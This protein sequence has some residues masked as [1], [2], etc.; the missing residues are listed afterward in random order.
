VQLKPGSRLRSTVCGTEVVVVRVPADVDVDLRCGGAP[1][2]STADPEARTG[3]P[4]PGLDGGTAV[5]KRYAGDPHEV[6]VLA[7]KS[8][9][10]TLSIGTDVLVRKL[11]KPLPASD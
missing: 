6:E 8:G 4:A 7:T 9:E 1:M 5:G 10:G 11:A 3:T 2:V